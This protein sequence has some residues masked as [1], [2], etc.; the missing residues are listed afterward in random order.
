MGF[1]GFNKVTSKGNVRPQIAGW[2]VGHLSYLDKEYR[3]F[4]QPKA[5]HTMRRL[6][7]LL[8][9]DRPEKASSELG[10][11]S[12]AWE[13]VAEFTAAAAADARGTSVASRIPGIRA[14]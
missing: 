9:Y 2:R 13:V 1:R 10:P 6:K 3:W 5:G 4:L 11:A 12:P 14:V 7:Q 8:S